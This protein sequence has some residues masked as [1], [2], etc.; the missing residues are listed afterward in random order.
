LLRLLN[1][2]LNEWHRIVQSYEQK[3]KALL[4]PSD[5]SVDT[6]HD[7]NIRIS[8]LYTETYYDYARSRRNKDALER[9]IDSIFKDSYSGKNE[10]ARKAQA[11]SRIYAYPVPG[12]LIEETIDLYELLDYFSYF[13]LM[14]DA[15]IQTL[16][17]KSDSKITNNSLLKLEKSII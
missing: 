5:N 7:F 9:L 16:K 17:A 14:L 12:S 10:A 2:D 15:T 3:N 8:E 1:E 6:L 13:Y 11:I 4:V